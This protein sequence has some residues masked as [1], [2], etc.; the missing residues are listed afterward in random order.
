MLGVAKGD[1]MYFNRE[2]FKKA[3]HLITQSISI[4]EHINKVIVPKFPEKYKKGANKDI[5]VGAI[6]CPF[7]DDSDPSF[8]YDKSRNF[9][10]CFGC[11]QGG[12][13]IAIHAS[14]LNAYQSRYKYSYKDALLDLAK[15]YNVD[16]P[17]FEFDDADKVTV[18][19]DSVK[20]KIK[21]YRE[22]RLKSIKRIRR[23]NV[24]VTNKQLRELN[25][26]LLSADLGIQCLFD[27]LLVRGDSYNITYEELLR[28][29]ENH[30]KEQV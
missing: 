11:Q 8:S 27:I 10:Y 21:D 29:F 12:N 17:Q 1:F 9:A 20:N 30:I 18:V 13:I 26:L 23:G 4:P 22:N 15:E 19:K 7:H 25:H 6:I 3:E 16:I 28:F 5:E 14:F 24:G 2:Q